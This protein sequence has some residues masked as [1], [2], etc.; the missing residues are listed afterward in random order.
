MEGE[1]ER[2]RERK[3]QPTVMYQKILLHVNDNTQER[4]NHS[5]AM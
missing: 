4:N 5:S 1:G 3:E 2:E